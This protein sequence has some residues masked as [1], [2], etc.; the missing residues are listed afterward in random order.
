VNPGNSVG[1]G[2]ELK[3]IFMFVAV[4]CDYG[5]VNYGVYAIILIILVDSG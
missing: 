5:V 2:E 1:E 3:G 4:I